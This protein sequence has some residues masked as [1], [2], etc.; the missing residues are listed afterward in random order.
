MKRIASIFLLALCLIAL[1]GQLAAQT[2][3]VAGPLP[4][5]NHS[6]VL[7]LATNAMVVFG[8]DVAQG[9]TPPYPYQLN[10]NDVWRLNGNLTWTALKPTGTPPASRG[11][12]SAVYD[13]LNTR[14]IIFGGGLGNSSPCANDVWVLTDATGKTG[15]PAW[16]QIMPSGTA[17]SPRTQHVA[18]YDPNTNSMIIYGGQ[19]CFSTTFADVWVLSEA[20]GIGGTPTWTQLSPVGGGPGARVTG[21]V[22]Y[23]SVNNRLIVFGGESQPGSILNND[24]WVLSNANGQGGIPTWTKLAPSGTL[25]PARGGN[26]SAYDPKNNRLIIFGGSSSCCMLNDVWILTNANGIGGTPAWTQLGPFSLFAE[27]RFSPTGVYN[28]KTNKMTIFGGMTAY[29][30]NSNPVIVV[31]VNDVWVLSHANGK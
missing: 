7:D 26:S 14:M 29:D 13:S 18:A 1:A 5:W 15:T 30:T 21:G 17:P 4:R 25:P 8:G 3:Q 2:W 11:G 22:A 23:D 28:P 16:V 31:S 10:L 19:N 24:V 6:A 12:H 20:N 27:G 9:N